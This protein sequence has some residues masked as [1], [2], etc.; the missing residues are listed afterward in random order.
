MLK[1]CGRLKKVDGEAVPGTADG[2]CLETPQGRRGE[3][4]HGGGVG[5]RDLEV[6]QQQAPV[7]GVNVLGWAL[8]AG[9]GWNSS[10]TLVLPGGPKGR[11]WTAHSPQPGFT[12]SQLYT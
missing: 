6:K 11:S 7:G 2:P 4:R 9:A 10:P 12:Q 5:C 8:R 1:S 3:R